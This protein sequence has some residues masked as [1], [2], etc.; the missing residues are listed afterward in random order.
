[1]R[2]FTIAGLVSLLALALLAVTGAGVASATALC[3]MNESPCPAKA[4]YQLAPEISGKAKSPSMVASPFTEKC[5]QSALVG[6]STEEPEETKAP[7]IGKITSLTFT[8]CTPC[9]TAQAANLPYK[10]SIAHTE[11]GKG[12]VTVESSGAGVPQLKLSKCSGGATCVYGASKI[13]LKFSG[14]KPASIAA[15]SVSLKLEEGS[16]V[17]CGETL[18]LTS[19]YSLETPSVMYAS[20][21]P[22][23][24]TL[25]S[26]ET[27]EEEGEPVCPEGKEYEGKIEADLDKEPAK[28]TFESAEEKATGTVSC[29]ESTIL[30][31]FKSNG[32]ATSKSGGITSISMGDKESSPCTSTVGEAAEAE[33]EWLQEPYFRSRFGMDPPALGTM[34]IT[35]QPGFPGN[36]IQ[37][38]FIPSPPGMAWH[39]FYYPPNGRL[40][41]TLVQ[42]YP[43]TQFVFQEQLFLLSPGQDMRCD[44]RARFSGRYNVTPI[45]GGTI[46]AG[47]AVIY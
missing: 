38:T 35:N 17:S 13:T 7:V 29:E 24:A 47:R 41:G 22:R 10:T 36:F 27:E 30:G 23:L 2:L 12:T 6:E 4:W 14:G 42:D 37:V 9:S 44:P 40:D 18:S 8:E 11:G 20:T 34:T 25:C 3:E 45:G 26:V 31:E 1:M 15:E 33:V 21:T 43:V 16:K 19:T 39:C 28:V 46:T 32:K 5:G